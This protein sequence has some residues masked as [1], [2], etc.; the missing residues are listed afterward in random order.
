MVTVTRAGEATF[1]ALLAD[2]LEQDFVGTCPA[3]G[4][5][6]RLPGGEVLRESFFCPFHPE[7]ILRWE[8]APEEEVLQGA[9]H[10]LVRAL[11][12]MERALSALSENLRE[13]LVGAFVV[14]DEEEDPR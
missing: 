11:L 3:C 1:E 12:D 10:P 5:A 4:F 6:V 13:G 2:I 14:R 9:E 7:R 8:Q